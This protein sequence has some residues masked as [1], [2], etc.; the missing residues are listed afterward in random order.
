MGG[1]LFLRRKA[2]TRTVRAAALVRAPEGGCRCPRSRY[3]L[4]DREPRGQDFGLERSDVLIINQLM[5][6]GRDGILTEK[7]FR[8]N[9]GA[10]IACP[11]TH[12]AVGEL[13]PGARKG[14]RELI[15][16]LHESPRDLL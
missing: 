14:V 3:Q 13:E 8:R 1:P 5:V 15:R 7:F 2:D 12:V 16:M 9:L 11:R 4:R 6:D 10:D